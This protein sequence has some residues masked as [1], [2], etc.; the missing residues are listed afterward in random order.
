MWVFNVVGTVGW[1][2]SHQAGCVLTQSVNPSQVESG[3]VGWLVGW[4]DGLLVGWLVW[5]AGWVMF[6]DKICQS[7][8]GWVGR[9]VGWLAGWLVGWLVGLGRTRLGRVF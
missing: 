4:L 6:F 7:E 9:L 5:V 1:F 8:A 3:W 2:W